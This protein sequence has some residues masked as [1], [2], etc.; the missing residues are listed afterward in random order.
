MGGRVFRRGLRT[1][2]PVRRTPWRRLRTPLGVQR[3]GCL[4][5]SSWGR[6]KAAHS[7]SE[8]FGRTLQSPEAPR[9][10]L[11]SSGW[12]D[13]EHLTSISPSRRMQS[14]KLMP[15]QRTLRSIAPTH[16]T[17]GVGRMHSDTLT[18][19]S[20]LRSAAPT[21]LTPARHADGLIRGIPLKGRRD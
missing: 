11:P 7:P 5:S 14:D 10:L 19:P 13:A 15:V 16:F 8:D 9:I 1:A 17:S 3:L 20:M 12:K 4:P 2:D 18:P 21:H 6:L